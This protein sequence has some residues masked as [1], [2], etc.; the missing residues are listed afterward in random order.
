MN[1]LKFAIRQLLKNPGFT[2][3]AVLTLALGIGANTTVFSWTRAVLLHPLRGVADAERLVTLETLTAAGGY[4][5]SSYPDFRDYRDQSQSLAGV[6]AFHDRPLSFGTDEQPERV[7]AEFVSGNF[8]DVLGVKPAAGRFFLFEEQ[9]E[10]PGKRSVAVLS[11]QFWQRRFNAD[12]TIIGK[13][14]RLNQQELTVVGIA[15]AN[16]AGTI[17]GLSF[18]VW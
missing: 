14:I 12:P 1:D 7:W 17:V 9:E 11:A 13:T 6:I 18:D 5:D 4:I 3:V 8:F 10:A 15:P 2:A 16:F